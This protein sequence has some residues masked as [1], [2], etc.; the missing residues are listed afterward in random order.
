M[1]EK[2]T[3]E[4]EL[5]LLKEIEQL[6]QEIKAIK[7]IKGDYQKT[8]LTYQYSKIRDSDLENLLSIEKLLDKSVFKQWFEYDIIID[9]NTEAM[10]IE[11]IA[12]NELLID[13]YSEED[14]KVNF[15]VPI[16]NKVHF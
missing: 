7:A 15:L 10:L 1:E 12:E 5:R 11:L 6:K 14:L 3:E 8:K 4:I 9:S 13:S 16:L 2:M